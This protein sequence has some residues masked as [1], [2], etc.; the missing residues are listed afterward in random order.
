MILHD[1][2]PAGNIEQ[3]YNLINPIARLLVTR[4][5]NTITK[6]LQQHRTQINSITEVGCGEGYL[7]AM[8]QSLQIAPVKA[9][10]VSPEIIQT[11]QSM[12][13][14]SG[15]EF[16][17]KDI[18]C[19]SSAEQADLI[20]CCE[21]LEHLEA[22]EKALKALQHIVKK[23]CLFSV[24]QEPLW[25]ALNMARGKY[26]NRLGNTPGHVNHWSVRSFAELISSYFTIITIKTSF[27]WTIV[28]AERN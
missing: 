17:V 4:F 1:G 7:A 19:L 24:P 26:I 25:R 23:Y 6:I 14:S 21:V 13:S 9:C 10:D 11:A 8:V 28:L 22:P 2:K 5:L 3:K 18:Y 12:Y 16:Y 20:L 27:P 15:V